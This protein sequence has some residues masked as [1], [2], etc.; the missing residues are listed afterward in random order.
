M[1]RRIALL[2]VFTLALS[3]CGCGKSKAVKSVEKQ[4]SNI[5]NITL[6]SETAL[7]EAQKAYD[8][9]TEEEKEKVENASL[10]EKSQDALVRMKE[11]AELACAKNAY[12]NIG[13][14]W[15]IVEQM[16][17]NL[18]GVWQDVIYQPEAVQS[19]GIAYYVEKTGMSAEAFEE[20]IGHYIYL[21]KNGL[22]PRSEGDQ[23]AVL[24]GAEDQYRGYSDEY[25]KTAGKEFLVGMTVV[26]F[27]FACE[28]EDI[29]LEVQTAM[30]DAESSMMKLRAEFADYPYSSAL[31]EY[32]VAAM[33]LLN[34]CDSP[35]L[36]FAEYEEQLNGYRE[37]ASLAQST[38][39]PAFQ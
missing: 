31:E 14:A 27:V 20:G 28:A 2:L 5:G 39:A 1:K 16:G 37:K 24:T 21:S 6:E 19:E 4:I 15:E 11:Q 17:E 9:L 12:K 29:R 18:Y 34:D 33:S 30:M 35:R 8:S 13:A 26:G 25:V 23:W 38:L 22:Q 10:L 36:S 32:R 3:L 7:S